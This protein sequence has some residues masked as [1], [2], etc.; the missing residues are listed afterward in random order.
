MGKAGPISPFPVARLQ[1]EVEREGGNN[2]K[3]E[4]VRDRSRRGDQE[5]GLNRKKEKGKKNVAVLASH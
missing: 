3:K 4:R 5:G 1:R 2:G